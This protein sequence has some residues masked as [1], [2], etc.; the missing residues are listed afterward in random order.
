MHG[1]GL[2]GCWWM[3]GENVEDEGKTGRGERGIV[4]GWVYGWG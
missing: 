1:R 3:R 4:V 2:W